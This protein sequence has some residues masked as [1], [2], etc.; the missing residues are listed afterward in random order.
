MIQ[1]INVIKNCLDQIQT[2]ST[3]Q[4][5]DIEQLFYETSQIKQTIPNTIITAK[6]SRD[7][8]ELI[9]SFLP[10]KSFLDYRL[11]SAEANRRVLSIA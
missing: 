11:V 7:N 4:K 1:N 6:L 5:S 3:T 10:F 8:H 9:F 2:T